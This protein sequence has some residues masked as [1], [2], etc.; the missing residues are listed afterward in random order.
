M[1]VNNNCIFFHGETP[2]P[3]GYAHC[4]FYNQMYMSDLNTH[5][6]VLSRRALHIPAWSET[7]GYPLAPRV[8]I[9][10][11]SAVP[12]PT[13]ERSY[14]NFQVHHTQFM[15]TQS[16]YIENGNFH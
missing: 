15:C 16:R 6:I 14:L 10:I 4:L 2:N 3:S 8:A 12:A 9:P 7:P 11:F 5:E 13:S 1:K